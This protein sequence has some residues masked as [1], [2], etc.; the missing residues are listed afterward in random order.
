MLLFSSVSSGDDTSPAL[1]ILFNMGELR[2][3]EDLPKELQT[4]L[5]KLEDDF[6]VDTKQLKSITSRFREELR[7]GLE[8]HGKNIV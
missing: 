6:T 3:T 2:K 1:T 7:E 5:K 4:E 8:E